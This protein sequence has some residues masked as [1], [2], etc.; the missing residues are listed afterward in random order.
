MVVLEKMKDDWVS[1]AFRGV[2]RLV[3]EKYRF[4]AWGGIVFT[5]FMFAG[6]PLIR[7]ETQI[8]SLFLDSS[9]VMSD[10]R[11]AEQNLHPIR[12]LEVVVEMDQKAFRQAEAWKKVDELQK[13]LLEIPEV[14]SVDSFLPLLQYLYTLLAQPQASADLYADQGAISEVLTLLSL[15]SDGRQLLHR[16]V[17]PNYG[18]VHITVRISAGPVSVNRA[19]E[20]VEKVSEQVM[21]GYGKAVVTGEQAVFAA[22]ASDLVDSQVWSVVLALS[23]ITVLL[24]FQLKSVMLGFFSLLPIIPPVATILGMMGWTGIPLD[25]VTVFATDIAI[26]LAIDD[27]FHYLTQMRRDIA[28]S[29]PGEG[30]VR[31]IL[32]QSYRVTARSLLSTTTPLF[33]GFLALA[34]TPTKPAIFF[35]FLGSASMLV[36]L[37]GN[38]IFL[39]ALILS[40]RVF[41]RLVEREARRKAA[42]TE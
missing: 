41:T 18:A 5:I 11:F 24:I 8:L 35:G 6:A 42:A 9:K 40:F 20:K 17:N 10:L 15:S 16:Y 39:P 3:F 38:T 21:K 13:R 30:R 31:E 33:L 12:T 7:I 37:F 26:G 1:A 29:E 34:A 28:A 14:A 27:T 36:A 32:R 19:I 25:N 23:A 22:Q 2:E 4:C